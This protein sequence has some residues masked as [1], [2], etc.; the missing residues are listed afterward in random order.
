MKCEWVDGV[1]WGGGR[2]AQRT[3]RG[4]EGEGGGGGGHDRVAELACGRGHMGREF[5]IVLFFRC[6]V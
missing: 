3:Q 5:F 6:F 1:G 4:P 2:R